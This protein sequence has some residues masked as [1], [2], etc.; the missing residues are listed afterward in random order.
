ML[1][2]K[3]VGTRYTSGTPRLGFEGQCLSTHGAAGPYE[4]FCSFCGAM[5]RTE[6]MF[7][8]VEVPDPPWWKTLK[9]RIIRGGSGN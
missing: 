3:R 1:V 6:I 4:P 9:V 2:Q 5:I 8:E 7:E